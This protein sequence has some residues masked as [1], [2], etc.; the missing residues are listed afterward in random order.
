MT[1]A[2]SVSEVEP[3]KLKLKFEM[4]TFISILVFV[5]WLWLA[6]ANITSGQK[7]ILTKLDELATSQKEMIVMRDTQHNAINEK[8]AWVIPSIHLTLKKLWLE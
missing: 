5:F 7:T 2:E 6:W 4:Q 8:F 1:E 3:K